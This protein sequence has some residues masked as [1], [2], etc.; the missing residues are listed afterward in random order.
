MRD[1]VN[2]FSPK[3]F[4]E[5]VGRD[6]LLAP[7]IKSVRENREIPDI[8][9]EGMRGTGKSCCAFIIRNELYGKDHHNLF[10]EINASH[11]RGIDVIRDKITRWCKL[12][13]PR[14]DVKHKIIFL[15]EADR[16]T[17]DALGC[18]RRPME[19]YHDKCRFIIA[20][21]HREMIKNKEEA[22]LS[23]LQ[24]YKFEPIQPEYIEAYLNWI[25]EAEGFNLDSTYKKQINNIVKLCKGDIRKSL[26]CL[27]QLFD[28]K[29]FSGIDVPMLKMSSIDFIKFSF[30]HEVSEM[31]A[32]LH[33]ELVEL[34]ITRNV[35]ISDAIGALAE[36]EY[37]SAMSELG[38]LQVQAAFAKIKAILTRAG[39]K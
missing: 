20:C 24:E 8:L 10:F 25:T 37:Y 16:L 18:L 38:L 5:L 27:D 34:A 19:D 30:N 26:H 32:K 31:F 12:A 21:N 7:L 23:R 36:Y 2:K 22:I 14:N 39:V 6:I 13:L 15:D 11:E 1:L 9:L 35:D 28:G 17:A 29:M 3:N 33:E 4:D